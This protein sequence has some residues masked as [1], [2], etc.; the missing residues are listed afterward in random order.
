M[1]PVYFEIFKLEKFVILEIHCKVPGEK[2]EKSMK[3]HGSG[4]PNGG[5]PVEPCPHTGIQLL[6]AFGRPEICHTCATLPELTLTDTTVNSSIMVH[7]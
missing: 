5:F 4:T 3:I 2:S 7:P 1:G 6:A